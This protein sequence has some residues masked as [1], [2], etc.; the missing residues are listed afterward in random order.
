MDHAAKNQEEYKEE[1]SKT[2]EQKDKEVIDAIMV[3]YDRR[4]GNSSHVYDLPRMT[5]EYM[6]GLP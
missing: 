2:L 5:V 1:V 4:H 3:A 6:G